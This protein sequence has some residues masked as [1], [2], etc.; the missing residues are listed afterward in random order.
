MKLICPL[1]CIIVFIGIPASA[2]AESGNCRFSLG[3][4]YLSNVEEIKDSYKH[5]SKDAGQDNDIY[6]TSISL[7]FQPYY[8]F[9]N[10]FR[11][12]AGFGPLVLL[13][14][15][16]RH[17]QLP[18]NTTL[19]YAFFRDSKI[20]TYCR[21]GISYH[22]A[23]GDFYEDSSPGLFSGIG[24]KFFNR[25]SLQLGFEAAYD[26]AEIRLN[27]ASDQARHEKIKTGELMLYLYADF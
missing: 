7:C 6:N 25:E 9:Q 14:G 26:A 13:L 22:I 20:M 4:S 15:D 12:G 27:R 2:D 18:V 24:V 19:G 10:G 1:F 5:L 3:Y 23:S 21:A 17:F 8:Q 11:V 16:A